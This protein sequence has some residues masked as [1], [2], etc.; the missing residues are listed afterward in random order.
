MKLVSRPEYLFALFGNLTK[1]EGVGQRTTTHLTKIRI[2]KPIDF[3]YSLPIGMK[4]RKLVKVVDDENLNDN[5]IIK[6]IVRKHIFKRFRFPSVIEVTDTVSKFNLVFFN[7]KREWLISN[8]PIN[9]DLVISGKLERFNNVFQIIH[10]EYIQGLNQTMAI[11]TVETLYSLTRGVSQ[12]LFFRSVQKVLTMIPKEVND[13]EWI[14]SNRISNNG[15]KGYKESLERVHNPQSDDDFSLNSPFRLR[16]A[17][18]DLFS[19]Q[20]CLALARKKVRD[21]SKN[22]KPILGELS[23]KLVKKLPFELTKAQVRCIGEVKTDLSNSPPMFRLLQ[24]DVGS[25]K[26]MVAFISML[27]ITENEGQCA[28]M[29]PTDLLAQQHYQ[30]LTKLI[31]DIGVKTAILTGKIKP[32]IREQTLEEIRTGSVQIIIG[33]HALFQKD[34]QFKNLQLA[35]I[36]EQHRFGV[37]Q[38]FD[39]IKKGD[40]IDILVMTATPIP[41]TLQLSNYGDLDVSIIDQKPLNRKKINTAVIS[42]SKTEPLLKRLRLACERGEQAYWVCPLIEEAENSELVALEKRFK[43]LRKF[44]SNLN[45]KILHGKMPEEEKND[46]MQSFLNGMIDVLL[47]TT[48]IEVGIDVPNASIMIIEGAERF[49]LAQLHQL[50]GRVGRGDLHSSCTLVYS[51]HLSKAG[52]ERLEILRNNSDGFQIAEE[53]LKMRGGGDPLGFQQSGIP[54]FR[55]ADLGYHS[56]ILSWAQEDARAL[57][58]RNPSLKDA[59]GYNIRLLLFLMGREESLSLIRSS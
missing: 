4:R 34:V 24:G 54:K 12:K 44:C 46:I 49:G 11:P 56:D 31:K 19:H 17:Y 9:E 40:L 30:N 48:V 51:N 42:E 43:V 5:I 36:D 3:L 33:T 16:L 13:I 57:I 59:E 7:A 14:N 55:L 58:H 47:A 53:D 20:V 10:P 35:V 32:K 45:V 29:V 28:L 23:E 26:T 18:D 21:S 22:R 38:R 37:K 2:S 15:W 50:R 1:L 8:F 41:R 6:V 52:K 39:L 25:G 27:F